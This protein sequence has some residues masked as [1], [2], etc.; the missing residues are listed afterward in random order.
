MVAATTLPDHAHEYREQGFTVARR[1]FSKEEAQQLLGEVERFVAVD[2]PSSLTEGGLIYAGPI[3]LR[4]EI[5]RRMLSDQRVLNL[6]KPIAGGDLWVTMDQALTKKPGAGIFRWHQDNGYNEL[7]R[8]HFQ[9]WIALTE[10]RKE[11]GALKLIPGSHKRGL[12]RHKFAGAGQMEV[13]EPLGGEPISINADVGDVILFSSLM[14][15]STGP[16]EADIDRTA[17]VAEFMRLE[18]YVP[19]ATPPFFIAAQGGF[20]VPHFTQQKP[21]ANSVRNQLMYLMPRLEKAAKTPLRNLRDRIY[22]RPPPV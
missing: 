10:T 5:C 15:H 3:F 19:W 12:L 13:D 11:N 17:Y 6:L 20:P 1:L 4:S 9:L 22:R 8:E 18:D 14:L 2:E 7:K 16:N 21:G